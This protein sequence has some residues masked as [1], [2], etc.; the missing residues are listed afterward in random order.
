MIGSKKPEQV[1]SSPAVTESPRQHA[2]APQHR[3]RN[4]DA[5][6]LGGLPKARWPSCL[7]PDCLIGAVLCHPAALRVS[8]AIKTEK[9]F[10]HLNSS[11]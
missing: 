2:A 5:E 1:I 8:A 11:A 7:T 3:P 10:T 6:L 9:H 4:R